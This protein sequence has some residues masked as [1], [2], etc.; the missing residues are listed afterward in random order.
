[1]SKSHKVSNFWQADRSY[2]AS[3]TKQ[4]Q[5]NK[6]QKVIQSPVFPIKGKMPQ[7]RVSPNKW[8]IRLNNKILPNNKKLP[9]NKL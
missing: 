6:K 4:Y 7:L 9:T 2:K 8:K 5:K 1:M 3:K